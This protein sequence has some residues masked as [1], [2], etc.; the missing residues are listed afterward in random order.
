VEAAPAL[1]TVA[2]CIP[3]VEQRLLAAVNITELI[4][5]PP[6]GAQP[7]MTYR[8]GNCFNCID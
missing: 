2:E 4:H 5:V 6:R 1:Y 8:T 7:Y 3:H